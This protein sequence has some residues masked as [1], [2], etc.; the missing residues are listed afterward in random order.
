[1]RAGRPTI[2]FATGPKTLKG[3]SSE[4]VKVLH[5]KKICAEKFKSKDHEGR[6]IHESLASRLDA[7]RDLRSVRL[8][9]LGFGL[10]LFESWPG[11]CIKPETPK[12]YRKPSL[13][14]KLCSPRPSLNSEL[15][16]QD[17][18]PKPFSAFSVLLRRAQV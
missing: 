3:R 10:G 6:Q 14:P 17:L 16:S 9:W 11:P 18:I 15:F 4:N 12:P 13:H 1:M 8:P 2:S 5:M 7:Q